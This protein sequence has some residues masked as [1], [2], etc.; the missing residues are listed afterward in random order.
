MPV[1]IDVPVLPVPRA[2][3][4]ALLTDAAPQAHDLGPL[5]E[6]AELDPEFTAA[7]IRSANSAASAP[8]E[9]VVSARVAVV[10]LG[11]RRS[12]EAMLRALLD[13]TFHLDDSG[14]DTSELW[15]HLVLC[16]VLVEGAV[17][18]PANGYTAG[19]LHDVGRMAMASQHPQAYSKVVTDVAAGRH[20]LD[21]E[22][23]VFGLSHVEWSVAAARSWGLSEVLVD[24]I[25]QHHRPSRRQLP[26]AL[27]QARRAGTTLGYGDG[28]GGGVNAPL[29]IEALRGRWQATLDTDPWAA[30]VLRRIGGTEAL[31]GR[32]GLH[33]EAES[34]AA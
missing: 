20:A 31:A 8:I 9:R 27:Y 28:L 12:R 21:A 18:R 3:A 30:P 17:G 32:I 5:V 33:A 24:A 16:A 34:S 2:R 10:R 1:R 11:P 6:L 15:R 29:T 4:F 19:L 26:V 7:V 22:R 25:A 14:I 23:A 13:D